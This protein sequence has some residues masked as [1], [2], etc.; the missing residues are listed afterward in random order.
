MKNNSNFLFDVA[1]SFAGEDRRYVEKTAFFLTRMGFRI[2]YDKYEKVTFW[3]KDLYSHLSDI[4]F[5]HARYA[6]IFIS[7]YYANKVWT[8]H[9]R[10]SAQARAFLS[11]KEYILPVRFDNTELPGILPTVGY[12]NLK[13]INPKKLAELIKEKIGFFERHEFFPSDID[14]LYSFFKVRDKVSKKKI[15][16]LTEHVFDDLCLM[17]REERKILGTAFFTPVLLGSK[18]IIFI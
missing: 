8:N 10:K 18:I 12:I 4:Y 9:E 14:K 5:R 15:L 7:K 13:E 11:K 17:T 2:F 16:D 6:V 1:L 3:G